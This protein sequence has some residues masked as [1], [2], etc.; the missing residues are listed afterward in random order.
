MGAR[1]NVRYAESML[2][3]L[4]ARLRGST[5]GAPAFVMPADNELQTTGSGLRYQVLVPG[6]GASPTAAQ[7]VTV[8]YAG[9]TTAG[10][11]FDSSYS[12]GKPATFPLGGVI[13]G[14]T[15]GLQLMHEGG[16][17][18]FVIPPALAYGSRGAPPDIGP[19]ATLVFRIE[20]LKVGS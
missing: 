9:W 1:P 18:L 6:D 15:E 5:R 3:K 12:R 13:A 2:K 19:N 16:T 10:R 4:L 20:L 14:W 11:P 8:H 17:A 7:S